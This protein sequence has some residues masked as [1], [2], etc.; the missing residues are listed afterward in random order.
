MINKNHQVLENTIVI[1]GEDR[2]AECSC[3]GV[4]DA[5]WLDAEDDRVGRWSKWSCTPK[6]RVTKV[7][8]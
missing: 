5:F 1:K 6:G 2:F 3:G 7:T 8:L 4:L